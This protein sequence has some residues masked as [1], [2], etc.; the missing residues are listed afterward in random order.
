MRKAP[1]RSF[2]GF[3]AF[4]SMLPSRESV[5]RTLLEKPLSYPI[6]YI[7]GWGLFE[8]LGN[9]TFRDLDRSGTG[10][11]I[12]SESRRYYSKHLAP[13]DARRL[14]LLLIYVYQALRSSKLQFFS[15]LSFPVLLFASNC[16]LGGLKWLL[17]YFT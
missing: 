11:E 4:W 10:F 13:R 5:V 16:I 15:G 6:R 9:L 2:F 1:N 17:L 3:E 12:S 14:D 7:A 8:E